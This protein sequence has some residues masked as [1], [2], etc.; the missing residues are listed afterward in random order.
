MSGAD[1]KVKGN[2]LYAIRRDRRKEAGK[3]MDSILLVYTVQ[4]QA[5]GTKFGVVT[6]VKTY[7]R[8]I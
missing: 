8:G 7:I 3:P 2:I 1:K 4:M 6:E 5:D